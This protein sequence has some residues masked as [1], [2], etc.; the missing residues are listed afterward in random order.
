MVRG[1]QQKH[2]H[3]A[4]TIKEHKQRIGQYYTLRWNLLKQPK[5]NGWESKVQV[6]FRYKQA[7]TGSLIKT[8]FITYP[9]GTKQ[10]Q[11]QFNNI[12]KNYANQGRIL[13]WRADLIYRGQIIDHKESYLWSN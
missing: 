2:L 13:S 6:V 3:G 10:G 7:S 8:A 4:V 1:D 5:L 12:G 9:A 11:W